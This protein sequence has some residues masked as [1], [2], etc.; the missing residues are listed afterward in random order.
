MSAEPTQDD[1]SER[2]LDATESLIGE[3]GYDRVRFIDVAEAAGVSIGSLQH[4]FRNREGLLRAALEHSDTRERNRWLDLTRGIDDPWERLIALIR[5]V[6]GMSRDVQVDNLWLQLLA[7]AQRDPTLQEIMQGQQDRWT[8]TFTQVVAEGMA[9]GRMT[10]DL[11][12]EEAGLALLALTDGFY[13]ATNIGNRPPD[14]ETITRIVELV[15]R[16][17]IQQHDV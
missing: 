2:I 5:S 3:R 1:R 7:V 11:T 16:R 10:S 6:L 4:R 17:V 13:L 12:A 14:V 9:S 8:M 15:A